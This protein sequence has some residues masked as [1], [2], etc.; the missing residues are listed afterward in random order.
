MFESLLK[1]PEIL[2]NLAPGYTLLK[3]KTYIFP[4]ALKALLYRTFSWTKHY[5]KLD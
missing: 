3:K 4:L 5:L 1:L 2:L